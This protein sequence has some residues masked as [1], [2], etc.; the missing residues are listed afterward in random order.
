MELATAPSQELLVRGLTHRMNNILTLFHGYLGLIMENQLLDRPTREGLAKIKDGA[1]AASELL[2]RTHAL[3]RPCT[4]VWREIDMADVVLML[5]PGCEALRPPRGRLSIECS[6]NLPRVRVDMS[7]LKAAVLEL[8][9]N[10]FEAITPHGSLVRIEVRLDHTVSTDEG[11]W[12]VLTVIDDGPG[13]PDELRDRIFQPFFSTKR[14]HN[15][16]GLGL[17]VAAGYVEQL[18]GMLRFEAQPGRTAFEIVLPVLE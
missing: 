4:G 3:V 7:R 5:T 9:R 17:N 8:V 10:A 11:G 2:D 13:V 12:V 16:T 18:G 6:E 1:S 14:K 15:A